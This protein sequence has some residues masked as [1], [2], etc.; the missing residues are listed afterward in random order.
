MVGYIG[1]AIAIHGHLTGFSN[2]LLSCIRNCQQNLD[3]HL[4]NANGITIHPTMIT[5]TGSMPSGL[6]NYN[7]V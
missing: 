2:G 3:I 4:T 5:L 7:L 1:V 6:E